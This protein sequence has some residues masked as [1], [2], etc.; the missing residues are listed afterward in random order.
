MALLTDRDYGDENVWRPGRQVTTPFPRR[1]KTTAAPAVLSP[2]TQAF[3]HFGRERLLYEEWM[4]DVPKMLF[5]CYLIE[6]GVLTDE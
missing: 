2:N 4:L 5:A 6:T 1:V 3:L